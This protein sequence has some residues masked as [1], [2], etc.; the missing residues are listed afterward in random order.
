M[1]VRR[2]IGSQRSCRE[3]ALARHLE[4]MRKM[5]R[6]VVAQATKQ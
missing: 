1:A 3:A 5:K 6:L 2:M 4:A